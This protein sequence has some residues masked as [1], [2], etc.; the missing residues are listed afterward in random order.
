MSGTLAA[1][2]VGKKKTRRWKPGTVARREIV[3]QQRATTPA[4]PAMAV[5]RL[6]RDAAKRA[7]TNEI[8]FAKDALKALHEGAEAEL[9]AI[10]KAARRLASHSGRQT[11]QVA[12][13]EL[14][15]DEPP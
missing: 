12:D 2:V 8:R 4:I 10:F 7:T 6:V 9:V 13:L 11:I 15:R 1:A 14:A 3:K 5:E